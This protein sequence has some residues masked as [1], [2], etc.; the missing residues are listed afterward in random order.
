[1]RA[2]AARRVTPAGG[3]HCWLTKLAALEYRCIAWPWTRNNAFDRLDLSQLEKLATASGM[4]GMCIGALALYARLERHLFLDGQPTGH[5]ISGTFLRGIP[6]GCP[7][8]VHWCN[9]ACWLWHV[10][11][12]LECPGLDAANFMDDRLLSSGDVLDLDAGLLCTAGV[13]AICGS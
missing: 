9:L 11:L 4:P 3:S 13:D 5:V 7:L 2:R 12:K 6:Q 8:S 1:M 10:R